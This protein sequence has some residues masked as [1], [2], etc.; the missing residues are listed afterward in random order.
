[1]GKYARKKKCKWI[2][3]ICVLVL[4]SLLMLFVMP[5]VLYKMREGSVENDNTDSTIEAT[6]SQDQ[7]EETPTAAENGSIGHEPEETVEFPVVLEEGA[8]E[9]ESLF[10]F[11]GVNPDADKQDATDAATIVLR[12]A[13]GKYLSEAV[14]HATLDS[15]A[16]LT[17]I[18]TELPAGTSA[19]AFCVDN[20][21][22][23]STDICTDIT[24]EATFGEIPKNDHIDVSVA[25]MTVT[26][27]NTSSEDMNEIDVYYR[28][29]FYDKYF[30][31]ITY[32]H[33]IS[34][35]PANQSATIDVA[36]SLLGMI[37]V[38]RIAINES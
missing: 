9:I 15:G 29:V 1:M 10:P 30:G 20:D 2:W 37:E 13:S 31:G 3:V 24:V 25:G 7:Q 4:V 32:K 36:D 28:D 11:S 38:V 18:A 21:S 5:Q 17:F 14:V 27:T 6:V 26:I 19:M 34:N 12:N 16:T 22:L 23:L 33:T 35:L 8:I